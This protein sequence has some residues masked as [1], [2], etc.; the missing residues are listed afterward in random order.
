MNDRT[1]SN[2]SAAGRMSSPAS[3]ATSTRIPSSASKSIARPRLVCDQLAACGIE[4]HAGR[5]QDRH[6]RRD[7]GAQR[8]RSGRRVGLRADMDALPMQE[9]ND[10]RV[11]VALRRAHARLRSRRPHD[12]AARG[13]PLPARDAQLRRHRLPDLPAGRGRPRGRE[14]DD[15]GRSVRALSGRARV[16]AAQLAGAAGRH[17][18]AS[19]RDRRWPPP[20]A[21]RS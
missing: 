3:G 16:R 12:D 2:T 17:A 4:H 14:S 15:R 11:P 18:S 8:Q 7:R 19:R 13:R 10:V 6:R 5:R 21:S 20:I 1:P 9:E